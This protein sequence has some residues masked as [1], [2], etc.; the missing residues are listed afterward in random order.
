MI[1]KVPKP[2]SKRRVPK[3]KNRNA[4]SEETRMKILDRDDGL[5]RVCKA[6]ATQIHHVK[7]KSGGGRG[8][9]TNGVSVCAKCHE[10]IHQSR[11]KADH[12]RRTFEILYGK[13]YYKDGFDL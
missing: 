13:N 4:F 6:P 5:C 2:R 12:W 8:V 3:Q 9:F 7:F 11:E 1:R 10:E